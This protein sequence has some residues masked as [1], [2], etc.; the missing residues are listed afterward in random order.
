MLILLQYDSGESLTS[1]AAFLHFSVTRIFVFVHLTSDHFLFTY[2]QINHEQFFS[3]LCSDLICPLQQS[4][5]NH[6]DDARNS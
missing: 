4:M 2:P 5:Q 6:T 1:L 3:Y